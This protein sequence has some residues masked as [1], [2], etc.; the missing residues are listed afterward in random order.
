MA[1]VSCQ[2]PTWRKIG[3]YPF[4]AS[5]GRA[6][7][8]NSSGPSWLG[9]EWVRKPHSGEAAGSPP[10]PTLIHCPPPALS[11]SRF[12]PP[13]FSLRS[14]LLTLHSSLFT[15]HCSLFTLPFVTPVFSIYEQT[16]IL[17]LAAGHGETSTGDNTHE[18]IQ[19]SSEAAGISPVLVLPGPDPPQL[20]FSGHLSGESAR[21]TVC[22]SIVGLGDRRHIAVFDRQSLPQPSRIGP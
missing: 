18:K 22:L 3:G 9:R 19:P 17:L 20:A 1:G 6:A 5:C 16:G 4:P 13:A 2:Y 10:I 12:S 8:R 14:P 21:A 7:R 15:L 11:F